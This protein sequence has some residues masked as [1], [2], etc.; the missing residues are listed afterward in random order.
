MKHKPKVKSIYPKDRPSFNEWCQQFK[1]S[2]MYADR[3]GINNAQFI[4][5]LWDGYS[6]MKEFFVKPLKMEI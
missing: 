4:M 2:S 6:N 1:V 5:S 3:E